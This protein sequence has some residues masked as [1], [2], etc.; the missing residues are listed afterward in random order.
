MGVRAPEQARNSLR[1]P[2]QLNLTFMDDLFGLVEIINVD[3]HGIPLVDTSI[4]VKVRNGARVTPSIFT[5]AVCPSVGSIVRALFLNRA[6]MTLRYPVAV[7]GV[8]EPQKAEILYAFKRGSCLL[9]NL[10]IDVVEIGR[11]AMS[12]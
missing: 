12:V 6:K 2:I 7:I 1:Q 10:P 9:N 8:N 3:G 4:I 5:A 11:C